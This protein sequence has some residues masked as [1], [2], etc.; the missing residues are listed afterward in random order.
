MTFKVILDTADLQE[1]LQYCYKTIKHIVKFISIWYAGRYGRPIVRTKSLSGIQRVFPDCVKNTYKVWKLEELL[2]LIPDIETRRWVLQENQLS[3]TTG[4]T[5]AQ[6]SNF[7][8]YTV[9]GF[10]MNTLI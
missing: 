9:S 8:L 3:M 10:E 2:S 1:R 6:T 5:L 7:L 4:A